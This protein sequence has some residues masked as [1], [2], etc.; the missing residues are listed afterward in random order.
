MVSYV[1]VV[2]FV[3]IDR[4]GT[5]CSHYVSE[6][7][8][9]LFAAMSNW[10]AVTSKSYGFYVVSETAELSVVVSDGHPHPYGSWGI[11]SCESGCRDEVK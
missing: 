10:V 8:V 9:L 6:S 1:C 7:C 2:L 11:S 5:E 3:D 4:V